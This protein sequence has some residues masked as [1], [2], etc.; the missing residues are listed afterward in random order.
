MDFWNV[1]QNIRN[2]DIQW[3]ALISKYAHLPVDGIADVAITRVASRTIGEIDWEPYLPLIYSKGLA[4]FELPV[5]SGQAPSFAHDFDQSFHIFMKHNKVSL[6]FYLFILFF[7][8]CWFFSPP[9][10]G[11]PD[12]ARSLHCLD[13]PTR[14]V[15]ARAP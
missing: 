6:H 7:I 9:A 3:M 14:G 4:S 1:M 10:S 2:W 12:H 13:H 15:I 11:V 8:F 5:G